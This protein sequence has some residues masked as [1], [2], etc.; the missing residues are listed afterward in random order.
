MNQL[1][2]RNTCDKHGHW[3]PRELKT[4]DGNWVCARCDQVRD[5]NGQ[6]L[7]SPDLKAVQP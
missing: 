1:P 3:F 2:Y 7:T 6:V 5:K 4:T